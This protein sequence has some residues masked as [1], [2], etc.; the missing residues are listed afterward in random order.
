MHIMTSESVPSF[1]QQ[2]IL[3]L[4]D[5][6]VSKGFP[7]GADAL[8]EV[9]ARKRSY[10]AYGVLPSARGVGLESTFPDRCFGGSAVQGAMEDRKYRVNVVVTINT[11]SLSADSPRSCCHFVVPW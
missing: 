4:G 6:K 2:D 7:G 5:R 8:P 10:I 1:S 9:F 3:T 11:G